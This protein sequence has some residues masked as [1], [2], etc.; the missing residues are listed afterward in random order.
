MKIPLIEGYYL[1]SI[2]FKDV[3][4]YV[5]HLKDPTIRSRTVGIEDA[6]TEYNAYAYIKAV[7]LEELAGFTPHWAIRREDGFLVGDISWY[8]R[9]NG[10]AELGWWIAS[11]CRGNGIMP[12]AAEVV[13]KIASVSGVSALTGTPAADNTSCI[14]VLLKCGFKLD[15]KREGVYV[16]RIS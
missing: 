10:E 5:E 7:T 4:A 15:P 6:F 14:R 11:S 3:P 8:T 16:L 9:D 1:D 13:A 12:K 2:N